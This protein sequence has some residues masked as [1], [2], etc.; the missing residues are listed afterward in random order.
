MQGKVIVATGATSGI[1]EI[2]VVELARMGARVVFIARDAKRAEATLAKLEAVAPGRGHR[3]HIADLSLIAEARRI[4]GEFAASEARID[5]L[6]NNAGAIFSDRRLTAGEMTFALNHM[7]Y[8]T[9]TKAL[10]ERLVGSAPARVVSTASA[11]HYG[12]KLDFDDLQCARGYS[13]WKA[14]NRSKLANILFTR[15]LAKRIA[16]T[17][18]SANCLHPGV[19]ASRFGDEAGGWTARLFPFIKRFAISPAQG[20]DTIVYLASSPEVEGVSGEYFAK[21]RVK[22]PSPAARDDAAAA[23]LWAMSEAI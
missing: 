18:V 19:V 16:G 15:E 9:L 20:A 22:A 4:G 8:F 7:A 21:R 11:A 13:A 12:V 14:Y 2:A 5:V 10:R 17:G 6:I 1:G 23:K 3:A